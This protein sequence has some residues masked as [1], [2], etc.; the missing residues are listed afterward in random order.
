[1]SCFAEVLAC[2][3]INLIIIYLKTHH[4]NLC[5]MC[6]ESMPKKNTGVCGRVQVRSHNS[7]ARLHIKSTSKLGKSILSYFPSPLEQV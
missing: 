4:I 2:D 5:C 7:L 1:M 3:F 6:E